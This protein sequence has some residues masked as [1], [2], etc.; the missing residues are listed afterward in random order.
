MSEK[1]M[2]RFKRKK[3]VSIQL[4]IL[5]YQGKLAVGP[6][7]QGILE[8]FYFHKKIRNNLSFIKFFFQVQNFYLQFVRIIAKSRRNEE[9]FKN[10]NFKK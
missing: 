3:T 10:N 8:I 2:N 1:L 6:I 7:K 4:Y 5:Y 9:V